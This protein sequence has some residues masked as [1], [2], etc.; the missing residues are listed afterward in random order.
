ME[1]LLTLGI[2]VIGGGILAWELYRKKSSVH[3]VVVI[4]WILSP[5]VAYCIGWTVYGWL[6]ERNNLEVYHQGDYTAINGLLACFTCVALN[7]GARPLLNWLLAQF[8]ITIRPVYW[9][10]A[11]YLV[12][13][14]VSFMIPAF[15]GLPWDAHIPTP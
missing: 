9:V 15:S 6:L 14:I 11:L 8:S 4:L 5:L 13:F 2:C 7:F 3:P 12:P 1:F 10:I